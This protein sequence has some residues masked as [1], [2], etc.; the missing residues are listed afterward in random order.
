MRN[1]PLQLV[2]VLVCGCTEY[3]ISGDKPILPL[4]TG[5]APEAW[6]ALAVDP[7]ELDFGALQ[8]GEEASGTVTVSN[9]GD[10]DLEILSVDLTDAGGVFTLT[11]PGNTTLVPEGVTT[12]VVTYEPSDLGSYEGQVDLVSDAPQDGSA[13][14]TLLGETLWPSLSI[15]PEFHDFGDLETGEAGYV[16]V[17]IANSGDSPATLTS[18]TFTSTSET[19]L[20]VHD[21]GDLASLP[22]VL[23]PLGSASASLRFSP[24]DEGPEEASLVVETDDPSNSELLCQLGG[25]GVVPDEPEVFEYEVE[26]L[27]TADDAYQAWIDGAEVTGSSS[28][29][30]SSYDTATATLETGDHTIA[31]YATDQYSVIAGFIAVVNVDGAAWSV[32]GDGSWLHTPSSPSSGWEDP[33]FDDSSWTTPIA[34]AD[35]SSWGSSPADLLGAGAAWVWW[36]SNCRALGES[37][38]RLNMTLP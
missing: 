36:D 34:C 16:D 28:S 24:L 38:F 7:L 15:T 21:E 9:T 25:N 19:E 8:P 5:E 22:L 17:L 27:V 1:L 13:T 23:D 2:F 6:P 33:A 18:M 26:L 4:D 29:S 20:L 30:W 31:V 37:W 3:E 11:Q 35:T 32:T 10:A 14:V 12:F